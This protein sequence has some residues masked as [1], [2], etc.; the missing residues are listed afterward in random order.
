VFSKL[1]TLPASASVYAWRAASRR[2]AQDS[3]SGWF[4][5]PFLQDSF[6]LYFMPVYPGA[7]GC[8]HS[9]PH[10]VPFWVSV[11]I[12]LLSISDSTARFFREISPRLPKHYRCCD[13][14]Q[15][16]QLLK[17]HGR[18]VVRITGKREATALS[19]RALELQEIRRAVDWFIPLRRDSEVHLKD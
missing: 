11:Y 1:N 16:K 5:T 2:P 10:S 14:R 3:R 19:V 18:S 8:P 15:R 6:I 17:K 7:S 12:L 4:A 9:V 13:R